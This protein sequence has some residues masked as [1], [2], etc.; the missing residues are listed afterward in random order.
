MT[1]TYHPDDRVLRAY[2]HGSTGADTFLETFG[3]PDDEGALTAAMLEALADPRSPCSDL[4]RARLYFEAH[5]NFASL[6][7]EKR[8]VVDS[9]CA[10]RPLWRQATFEMHRDREPTGFVTGRS[11]SLS[12]ITEE[13]RIMLVALSAL[14]VEVLRW[15]IEDTLLDSRHGDE[16]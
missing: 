1:T 11:P 9:L 12:A 13:V 7:D 2:L 10:L 8:S 5:I 3:R 16:L 4:D 14:G 15:K 6:G